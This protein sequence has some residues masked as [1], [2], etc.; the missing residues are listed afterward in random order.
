[1]DEVQTQAATTTNFNI[2]LDAKEFGEHV[3]NGDWKLGLLVARSV[4]EGTGGPRTAKDLAVSKISL[5]RF[6]ELAGISDPTV[7]K[8]LV[9]WDRAADAGLVPHSSSL[10]PGQS[11]T[12]DGLPILNEEDHT[13]ATWKEH[14]SPSNNVA[15]EKTAFDFVLSINKFIENDG[16]K[17]AKLTL[18]DIEDGIFDAEHSYA[19]FA[20]AVANIFVFFEAALDKTRDINPGE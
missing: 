1:M 3:K 6:A 12:D 10:V 4:E 15:P 17:P 11:T 19:D 9:A 16:D 14:Y 2:E 7:K 18:D 5:R 20:N 8:Y 13:K